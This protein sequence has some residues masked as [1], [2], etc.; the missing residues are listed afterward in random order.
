MAIFGLKK[1]CSVLLFISSLTNP[2]EMIFLRTL[3][4]NI[5]PILF[6]ERFNKFL[7]AENLLKILEMSFSLLELELL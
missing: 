2:L 3:I 5:F 4:Q 1:K 7:S 6:T